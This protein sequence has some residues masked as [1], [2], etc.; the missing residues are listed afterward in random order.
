MTKIENLEQAVRGLYEMQNPGRGDWADWLYQNHVFLVANEASRL[1]IKYHAN[2]PVAR[3]AAL[4]HD[5]A[6]AVMPRFADGHGEKS[7]QIAREL[8]R[9]SGYSEDEISLVAEDALP[10]H[11]CHG[12]DRPSTLEGKVLA[13]A[14][15][16]VHLHSDFYIYATWARGRDGNLNE[17]KQWAREKIE[18]DYH[19]KVLFEDERN[20]L[21]P[22]YLLLKELFSR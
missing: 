5:C 15:A 4:L 17:T 6:D 20:E 18:R 11:G 9:Q 10:L 8:L 1:A 2:E 21:E 7:V 3:G 12:S 19:N 16:Y 14:D 22:D 13:T